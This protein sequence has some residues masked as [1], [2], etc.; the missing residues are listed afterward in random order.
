MEVVGGDVAGDDAEVGEGFGGGLGVDVLF[1]GAGVGKGGDGGVGEDFG[2]VE[3]E[4]APAASRHSHEHGFYTSGWKDI[5]PQIEHSHA[6]FQLSLLDVAL[7]HGNLGLSQRLG[8][9]G[10]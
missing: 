4:G 1:L 10:I 6:I 9:L 5:I 3:G 2:E 8:S 7:Q